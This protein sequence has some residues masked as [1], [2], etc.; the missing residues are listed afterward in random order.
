MIIEHL[1]INEYVICVIAIAY[2]AIRFITR[3]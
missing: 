3:R 2:V 1:E